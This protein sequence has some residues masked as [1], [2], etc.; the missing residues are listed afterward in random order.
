MFPRQTLLFVVISFNAWVLPCSFAQELDVLKD[1]TDKW[2]RTR[3]RISEEQSDWISDKKLIEGSI[4]TL[5]STRDIL[6][7]NVKI[8]ETQNTNLQLEIEKA[9]AK[10][11]TFEQ[12]NLK[13]LERIV[14]FENRI[15][16]LNRSLPDPLK[17]KIAPLIRKIPELDSSA[18]PPVSHRLQNVI[19]IATI[20]DEFNN[21]L[22]HSNIIKTLD[23]GEVIQVRVLYWG[24]AGA[25][26]TNA[27]GSKA[28]VI[29]PTAEGWGWRADIEN[30]ENI[31]KLFDVYDKA[32]EPVLVTIPFNFQMQ[33]G[34]G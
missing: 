2:I 31:K 5:T 8:L 16:S 33:G 23:D 24:L 12:R 34:E 3:N 22:S 4:D 32:T 15:R 19:T 28:W 30:A 29:T 18:A 25:Y 6:K 9:K 1:A 7:D 14:L 27:D 17:E 20:I 13:A 10:I 11:E 21:D 26:A